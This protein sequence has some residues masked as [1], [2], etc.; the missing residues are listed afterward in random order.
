MGNLLNLMR[1]SEEKCRDVNQ[2]IRGCKLDLHSCFLTNSH[3][4]TARKQHPLD[5]ILNQSSGRAVCFFQER[6]FAFYHTGGR[7]V[8]VPKRVHVVLRKNP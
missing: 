3:F 4:G 8:Q 2:F 7:L 5:I 6:E 1:S